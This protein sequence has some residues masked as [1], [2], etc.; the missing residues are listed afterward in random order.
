M[1]FDNKVVNEEKNYFSIYRK[2]NWS[3]DRYEIEII[4]R[5]VY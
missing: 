3:K 1:L 5:V 4:E 2:G